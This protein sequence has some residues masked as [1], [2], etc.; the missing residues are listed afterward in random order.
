MNVSP[1][2]AVE[3][4]E[5]IKYLDDELK[6]YIPDEFVKYLESIKSPNYNF[7]IDK[8]KNLFENDFMDETIEILMKFIQI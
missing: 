6:T 7:E 5:V 2:C 4:L 8:N 3:L 1:E